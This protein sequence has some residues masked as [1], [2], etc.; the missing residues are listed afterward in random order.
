MKFL[1]SPLDIHFDSEKYLE[2]VKELQKKK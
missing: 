1:K 2:K